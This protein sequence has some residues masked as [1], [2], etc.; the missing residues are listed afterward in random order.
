[1]QRMG[2]VLRIKKGMKNKYIDVHKNVCP[3]VLCAI[4]ESNI[5]NNSTFVN[6]DL[7]FMYLEYAGKD[8]FNDW[9]KYG[10]NPK[11]QEWFTELKDFLEPY[12]EP[13]PATKWTILEEAFHID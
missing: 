5:Q 11:V 1:M 4:K 3:E 9:R 7:L 13:I 8:F 6:D 12:E 2:M 10:S